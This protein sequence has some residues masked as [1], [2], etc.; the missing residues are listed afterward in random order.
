[1][2]PKKAVVPWFEGMKPKPFDKFMAEVKKSLDNKKGSRLVPHWQT[3]AELMDK[4][5]NEQF[6]TMKDASGKTAED[7]GFDAYI[8][9]IKNAVVDTD[10]PDWAYYKANVEYLPEFKDRKDSAGKTGEDY[11]FEVFMEIIESILDRENQ[12][13][14]PEWDNYVDFLKY[15][16][17][18]KDKKDDT[19]KSAVDYGMEVLVKMIQDH[20]DDSKYGVLLEEMPEFFNLKD[21]NGKTPVMYAAEAGESDYMLS[22]IETPGV[23]VRIKDN[24]GKTV[25]QYYEDFLNRETNNINQRYANDPAS[26]QR[27]LGEIESN[28]TFYLKAI[29]DAEAKAVATTVAPLTQVSKEFGKLTGDKKMDA[30]ALALKGVTGKAGEP[31]RVLAEAKQQLGKGRK[32]RRKGKKSKKS[33]R[34]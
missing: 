21:A 27:E 18:F 19:G 29:K 26:L 3:Y 30:L 32:T 25:Y 34:A 23:D 28:R 20:E 12:F 8:T 13:A 7:Y 22:M 10:P 2:P 11:G 1:M 17:E 6:K 4:P 16:I 33:R 31:G 14:S 24:E 15:F 9:S 5:E